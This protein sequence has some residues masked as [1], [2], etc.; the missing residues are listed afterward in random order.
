MKNNF[1]IPFE[2]FHCGALAERDFLLKLN[3]YISEN[4]ITGD[5]QT[6]LSEI[7]DEYNVRI[8]NE[9]GF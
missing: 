6:V 7:I 8:K 5:V 9:Y 3:N 2:G 1:Y 4:N